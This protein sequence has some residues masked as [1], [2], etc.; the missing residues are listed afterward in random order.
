MPLSMAKGLELTEFLHGR[1]F[2]YLEIE[3]IKNNMKQ[4]CLTVL[5][6][7]ILGNQFS[8]AILV[9]SLIFINMEMWQ[10]EKTEEG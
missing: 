1:L 5:H 10:G 3:F 7:F 4:N 9:E 8:S 2:T 6:T